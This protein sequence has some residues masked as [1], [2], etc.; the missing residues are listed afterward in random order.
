MRAMMDYIVGKT[1]YTRTPLRMCELC[2]L[3][4][5]LGKSSAFRA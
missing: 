4:I 5:P 3:M 1:N 2:F